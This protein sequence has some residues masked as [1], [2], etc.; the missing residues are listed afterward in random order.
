M[1]ATLLCRWLLRIKSHPP[2]LYHA[3]IRPG[4]AAITTSKVGSKSGITGLSTGLSSCLTASGFRYLA[5]TYT[6]CNALWTGSG[7][8]QPASCLTGTESICLFLFASRYTETSSI[9]GGASFLQRLFTT[10][11]RLHLRRSGRDT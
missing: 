9:S 11:E 2:R 10:A 5:Q 7:R 1:L 3:I 6:G 8:Y 4:S